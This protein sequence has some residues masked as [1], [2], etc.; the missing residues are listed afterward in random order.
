MGTRFATTGPEGPQLGINDAENL[1]TQFNALRTDLITVLSGDYLVTSP[2]LAIGSTPSQVASGA[3]TYVI[4][5]IQYQKAAVA[6][7]TAFT[8][9]TH[10]IAADKEAIFV[11]SINAGGTITITKGDDA[12]AGSAVAPD[13]PAG[14][15]KMGEVKVSAVGDTFDATTD[16]LA[17]TWITDTYT[18][19]ALISASLTS[20]ALTAI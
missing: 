15:C 2:A 14:E 9:T 1:R 13:T 3:F 12:D 6:A 17:E 7:G 8:A 4:D 11:L 5:G 18:N 19:A 20:S 16:S 10:D